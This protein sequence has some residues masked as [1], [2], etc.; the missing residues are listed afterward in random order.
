MDRRGA[1]RPARC[2]PGRAARAG[3]RRP[4][5]FAWGQLGYEEIAAALD[6]PTGTVRSRLNRARRQTGAALGPD[7]PLADTSEEIR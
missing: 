5:V 7:W 3:P 2:R 6:V 4:A 1:A